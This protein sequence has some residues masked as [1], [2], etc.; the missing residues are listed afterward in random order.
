MS[1]GVQGGQK[2]SSGDKTRCPQKALEWV[3]S[4]N[5]VENGAQGQQREVTGQST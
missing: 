2:Y 4:L 1:Q 3:W 5:T